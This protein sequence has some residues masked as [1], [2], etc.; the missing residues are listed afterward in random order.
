MNAKCRQAFAA[1]QCLIWKGI[2]KL[3]T[4]SSYFKKCR[5]LVSENELSEEIF[6]N[7]IVNP[8]YYSYNILIKTVYLNSIRISFIVKSKGLWE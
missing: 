1:V 8:K 6:C 2:N 3:E 4:L 7:G 5:K